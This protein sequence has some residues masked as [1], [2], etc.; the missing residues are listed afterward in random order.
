[1]EVDVSGADLH[2]L[3]LPDL[4]VLDRVVWTED[5]TWPAAV[6]GKVRA[7]SEEIRPGVFQV[8]GSEP[9]GS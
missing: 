4:D 5:T 7:R 3:D 1:M 9:M 8:R 6:S 2:Q